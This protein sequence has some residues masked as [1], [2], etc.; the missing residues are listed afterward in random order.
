MRLRSVSNCVRSKKRFFPQKNFE[1]VFVASAPLSRLTS[2]PFTPLK[3]SDLTRM[4]PVS[5]QADAAKTSAASD[6]QV[7]PRRTEK[8][9]IPTRELQTMC[10]KVAA[11]RLK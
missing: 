1:L 6:R 3:F 8:A 2:T 5:R 11:A 4:V 9:N 10:H 7:A